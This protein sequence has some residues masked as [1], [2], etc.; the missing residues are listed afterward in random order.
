MTNIILYT[1]FTLDYRHLFQH[2]YFYFVL[3]FY[4]YYL[5]IIIHL[6]F[7]ITI[8]RNRN[9]VF[10]NC[11]HRSTHIYLFMYN[12]Y[13]LELFLSVHY[14]VFLCEALCTEKGNGAI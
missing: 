3:L 14:F 12:L 6:I 11:S 2:Y 5:S 10:R 13:C 8:M 7:N 9:L 1:I 4:Y